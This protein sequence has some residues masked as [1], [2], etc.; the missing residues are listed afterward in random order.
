MI[1]APSGASVAAPTTSLPEEIGGERNWDYRFCWIRDS[2]FMI[3]ALLRL[4]CYDEAQ[5]LFWWFMQATAL[6]QPTCT[7]SIGSTAGRARQ[8]ADDALAGYRGSRPVRIGNGAVDQEQHDI[9]GELFETAWLYSRGRP[10]A[11]SRHG[12]A[13]SAA[14]PITCA[15]SG[16]SPTP[17][18]GRCANGPFHFTH[19]KVMC[20]VALDRAARLADAREMPAAHAAR[21]RREAAAID[22]YVE[23]ECW[24]EDLAQLH[25]RRR[26][27]RRRREPADAAASWSSAIRAASAFAAPS[28][29][30]T[31]CCAT[32]TSSTGIARRTAC[33]AAKALSELLVLA[34]ER[35]RAMRTHRR[36]DGADGRLVA[37]ANDVGLYAEEIDPSSGAF[38]GNFPQALVHLCARSTRRWPARRQAQSGPEA[39]DRGRSVRRR[40]ARVMTTIMRGAERARPD[41]DG[42]RA[43]ARHRGDRRPAAGASCRLRVP[44]R[45]RHRVRARVRRVLRD[46]SGQRLCWLGA[47]LGALQAIFN[48]TVLVNVL[49]P[50]VHPRI[51]NAGHGGQ[52]DRARRAAGFPHAELRAQH[53]PVTLAAHLAYGAIVAWA[54]SDLG[55][56]TRRAEFVQTTGLGGLPGRADRSSASATTSATRAGGRIRACGDSVRRCRNLGVNFGFAPMVIGACVT[57][58]VVSLLL[59]GAAFGGGELLSALSPSTATS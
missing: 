33:P 22:D 32:A 12:R 6:T 48:G 38:L 59:S 1:F 26:Q 9:Y 15:T 49:L 27:P 14:S 55:R 3:D 40:H 28:T 10:L 31:G 52:R 37:R 51:G 50:I 4:G 25:A 44:L 42:P 47:L 21:W 13:C 54:I 19:S 30:S 56:I 7:C 11:G 23:R 53:V 35:V 34:G 43:P 45:P 29:P 16:A 58:W 46:P 39:C 41:A 18:S 57:L 24:S 20:W 36:R 2:N 8:R 5:S 17:A